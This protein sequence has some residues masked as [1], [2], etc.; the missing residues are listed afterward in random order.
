MARSLSCLGLCYR[1]LNDYARA[2]AL[3]KASLQVT[4]KH[5]GYTAAA[6]SEG[7]Q[8]TMTAALRPRLNNYVAVV[9]LTQGQQ[10]TAYRHVLQWKGMVFARQAAARALVDDPELQPL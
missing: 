10:E 8:L 1:S 9:G 6:Q 4:L 7:Q 5:L 2:E 3:L